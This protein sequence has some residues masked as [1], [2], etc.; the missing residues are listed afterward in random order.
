MIGNWDKKVLLDLAVLF[1]KQVFPKL[2][3]KV[4]FSV[5]DKFERKIV[6]KVL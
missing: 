6:V 5:L 4:T 3:T 2:A 1:N